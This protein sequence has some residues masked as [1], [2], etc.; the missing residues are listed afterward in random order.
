MQYTKS[1]A[2]H[3]IQCTTQHTPPT[4]IPHTPPAPGL[5]PQ[6]K[7]ELSVFGISNDMINVVSMSCYAL[8]AAVAV[9]VANHLGAGNER[10]A[11]RTMRVALGVSLVLGAVAAGLLIVLRRWYVPWYTEDG[12]IRRRTGGAMVPASL[13][14]LGMWCVGVCHG[15]LGCVM[16]CWGMTWSVGVCHGHGGIPWYACVGERITCTHHLYRPPSIPYTTHKNHY[17]TPQPCHITPMSSPPPPTG[18]SVYLTLSGVL[19]GAGHQHTAA[20]AYLL[21]AYVIGIPLEV[22]FAFALTMGV[23]GIWWAQVGG[24]LLCV[25]V[26]EMHCEVKARCCSLVCG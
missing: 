23:N 21:A 15:V 13:S 4:H 3:A 16:E 8:A 1:N 26:R 25:C 19:R 6:S 24:C 17:K 12:H 20:G 2:H 22:W 18:N 11:A 10:G 9:K 7:I 5:L 14:L